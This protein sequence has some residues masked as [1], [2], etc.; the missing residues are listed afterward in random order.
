MAATAI[1]ARPA[2]RR[3][4]ACSV[5]LV[6]DGDLRKRDERFVTQERHR[7]KKDPLVRQEREVARGRVGAAIALP[8]ERFRLRSDRPHVRVSSGQVSLSHGAEQCDRGSGG[9]DLSGRETRLHAVF[10]AAALPTASGPD[11]D[12]SGDLLSQPGREPQPL[13]ATDESP[14]RYVRG[15]TVLRSALRHGGAGLRERVLQQGPHA[16]HAAR[17]A[18]GRWAVETVLPGAQHREARAPWLRSI[19]S[20]GEERSVHR[21]CITPNGSRYADCEPV[22][23]QRAVR[24]SFRPG[25]LLTFPTT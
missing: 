17:S 25:S 14:H 13:H 16:L 6:A 12:T 18:E 23:Y 22:A 10:A 19:E 3:S 7:S 15:S 20:S 5:A 11:P 4:P 8:A 1:T 21:E 24:P 9:R 2:P